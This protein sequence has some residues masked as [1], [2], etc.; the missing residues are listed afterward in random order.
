MTTEE[1]KKLDVNE[2]RKLLHELGISIEGIQKADQGL[3]RL[4]ENAYSL[5]D[6]EE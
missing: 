6:K 3:T 5:D 2:L 4:L 1:L